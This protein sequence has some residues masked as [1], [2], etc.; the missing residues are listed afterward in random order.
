MTTNEQSI[1]VCPTC[2]GVGIL[3]IDQGQRVCDA[4][5]GV[6]K[7]LI[8]GG[9]VV[10]WG[11]PLSVATIF[12]RKAERLARLALNAFAFAIGVLGVVSLLYGAYTVIASQGF[13]FEELIF[14]Q[15]VW[16]T[17]FWISV[18]AD[19]YVLYR[20]EVESSRR[21]FV[22]SSFRKPSNVL[23]GSLRDLESLAVSQKQEVSGAMSTHA[24]HAIE[25]AWLLA[26]RLHH[27][28]V[29]PVHLFIALL[30]FQD[31]RVVLGRLQLTSELL[32]EKIKAV[33]SAEQIPSGAPPALSSMMHDVLLYA[34]D[35]ASRTRQPLVDTTELLV[36]IARTHDKI[37]DSLY[38]LEIDLPVLRNVVA[39]INFQKEFR[40][41]FERHRASASRKPKSHMNRAMTARPTPFL[42]QIG[43]DLT[44][45]ARGGVFFPLVG[46]QDEVE[47]VLHVFEE[48]AGNVL[49]MGDAGVGKSAVVEGLADLMA[50]EDVP[51][52]IRDMRLV[53]LN[54]GGLFGSGG[55]VESAMTTLINEMLAA[56]NVVLFIDDLSNLLG[57]GSTSSRTMD[58]AMVLAQELTRGRIRVIATTTRQHYLRYL[59]NEDALMR[60]FQIVE[61][62]EM[63]DDEA[64]QTVEAHST[65]FEHRHH[66]LFSYQAVAAA[67]K[68]SR[69]YLHDRFLPDKAMRV[70]EEAAVNV[71]NTSAKRKLV[72]ADDIAAVISK[73]THVPV[74]R[75]AHDEQQLL[76]H[77]EDKMHERM[78]G[79]E[80]AVEM[81]AES[82]RRARTELRDER[83]PIIN[84]LF[85]GPTGVG[86]TELAKTTADVYFGAETHMIRLDMSEYQEQSSI[87]RL[88]GAPPGYSS[89]EAGGQL[90]DAVRQHPFALVLLDEFEKAHPEILNL[91]LQVMDD[92][93]LS[94]SQ[95][96]EV[97]F[98]NAM[99]IA[100]SNAGTQQ[101][102][103]GMREGLSLEQIRGRLLERELKAVFRPELL[104]RF[105]GVIVFKPLEFEEVVKIAGLMFERVAHKMEE[106]GIILQADSK[107]LREL[108]ERGFD[109]TLGARPLR[110]VIQD[111]VDAGLARLLLEGKIARRDAVTLKPGGILEVRKAPKL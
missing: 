28:E 91:F 58:A 106:K 12:E 71:A 81:V 82:L 46:R 95:G 1:V 84:L 102:Q 29:R 14:A 90:T 98:T 40:R 92:G 50:S 65:I 45:D 25:S 34:Y 57:A 17:F 38:D 96:R 23:L 5:R 100:T 105:D 27:A 16:Y 43:R 10:Y 85:L 97:D 78:V 88:I 109:P 22:A 86:K 26:H 4:C 47:R 75:V 70:A 63:G 51:E 67:V 108:S 76:L 103:D 77:L 52:A 2:R 110:R 9:R 48:G 24:L 93:R 69:R 7:A 36:V 13:A 59:Q 3:A 30:E 107:A 73:E 62:P 99:I 104:N 21:A 61:I 44:L 31:I 20:L 54:I 41:D 60:R 68:L 49:L 66:V 64:I 42:D 39:W 74:D 53:E 55:N 94:D 6:G 33:L 32:N 111:T 72:T 80:D 83:R 19:G 8:A 56:G 18:I 35:E 89:S 79:Q 11:L 87:N 101:I 15:N 37:A